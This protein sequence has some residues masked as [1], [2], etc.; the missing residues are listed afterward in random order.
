MRLPTLLPTLLLTATALAAPLR[1]SQRDATDLCADL[2]LD[3]EGLD[4][5]T[6]ATCED[7][8]AHSDFQPFLQR[9]STPIAA[10]RDVR[11]QL[12]DKLRMERRSRR[13][14]D[15]AQEVCDTLTQYNSTVN[16]LSDNEVAGVDYEG[17][18]LLEGIDLGVNPSILSGIFQTA[19]A[20]PSV[21]TT[22]TLTISATAPHRTTFQDRK[23]AFSASLASASA[24]AASAANK[25]LIDIAIEGQ[26]LLDGIDVTV[27]PDLLNSLLRPK[28]RRAVVPLPTAT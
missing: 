22:A 20:S 24:A 10:A 26:G 28:T 4:E 11:D 18:G 21:A 9:W 12:S 15:L 25:P 16:V 1:L 2:T 5:T 6:R 23:S 8:L 7:L 27:A 13:K 19:T 14:R 17:A 3:G